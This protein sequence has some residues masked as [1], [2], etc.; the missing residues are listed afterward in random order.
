MDEY[1]D[2]IAL[3]VV[4]ADGEEFRFSLSPN[5][6]ES[7]RKPVQRPG[8]PAV[9]AYQAGR[10]AMRCTTSC[11]RWDKPA[12]V[13]MLG[14]VPHKPGERVKT[15]RRDARSLRA[16]DLTAVWVPDEAH[17]ALRG[18]VR[19]HAAARTDSAAAAPPDLLSCCCAWMCGRPPGCDPGGGPIAL[20]GPPCG[21]KAGLVLAAEAGPQPCLVEGL[22]ALRGIVLVTA[23][24]LVAELG[25]QPR[26]LMAYVG[27]APSC[28]A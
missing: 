24:T 25:G 23:A 8:G 20:G 13:A 26:E 18:L 15:D 2:S 5:H 27:Q 7:L 17:E 14:L 12:L 16:G 11:R 21:W 4:V 10:V 19:A 6:A 9:F 3:A 1:K 22:Q 28:R